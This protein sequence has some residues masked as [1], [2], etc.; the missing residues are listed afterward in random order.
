HRLAAAA[1]FLQHRDAVHL[2]QTEVQYHRVIGFGIAQEMAFL[3]VI[4]LVH[5]I[6]GIGQR[7]FQQPLQVLVVFHQKYAHPDLLMPATAAAAAAAPTASA[8]VAASAAKA[9][10]AAVTTSAAVAASDAVT[11]SAAKAAA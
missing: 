5:D 9:A 11:G 8:A 2:G 1:P 3:A 7:L 6:T 10:F 4:C